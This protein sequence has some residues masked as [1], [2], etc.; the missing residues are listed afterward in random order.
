ML[1]LCPISYDFGSSFIIYLAIFI[2]L[3]SPIAIIFVL[4]KI[5][6]PPREL[7]AANVL[8]LDPEADIHNPAR[9]CWSGI[10]LWKLALYAVL[11]IMTLIY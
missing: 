1:A 7:P 2:L 10:P 5:F 8:G 3:S 4:W 9:F 11:T 6:V